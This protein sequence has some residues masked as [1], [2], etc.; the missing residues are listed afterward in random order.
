MNVA[1]ILERIRNRP[2][3]PDRAHVS[4]VV[5]VLKRNPELLR[6]VLHEPRDEDGDAN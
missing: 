2:P 4:R 6:L 3:Q 1:D 5:A